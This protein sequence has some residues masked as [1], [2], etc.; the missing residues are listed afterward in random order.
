MTHYIHGTVFT[1]TYKDK[2]LD[3]SGCDLSKA[4]FITGTDYGDRG[5][6]FGILSRVG[7]IEE[8]RVLLTTADLKTDGD[9]G[10]WDRN[11]GKPLIRVTAKLIEGAANWIDIQTAIKEGFL[12]WSGFGWIHE[13]RAGVVVRWGINGVFLCSSGGERV[14]PGRG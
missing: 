7:Q 1:E 10:L 14:F 12:Q 4:K 9:R 8:A 3:I 13:Y 2:K 6:G 11:Q 5:P